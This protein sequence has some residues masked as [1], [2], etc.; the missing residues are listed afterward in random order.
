[1]PVETIPFSQVPTRRAVMALV[2]RD[3]IEVPGISQEEIRAAGEIVASVSAHQ[4]HSARIDA[5]R[6]AAVQWIAAGIETGDLAGRLFDRYSNEQIASML[7]A[8]EAH[9]LYGGGMQSPGC[10]TERHPAF[11]GLGKGR[12]QAS[13]G[14]AWT[15][16]ISSAGNPFTCQRWD[17]HYNREVP[18]CPFHVDA[19]LAI[20]FHSRIFIDGG[21]ED[22]TATPAEAAALYTPEGFETLLRSILLRPECKDEHSRAALLLARIR[23]ERER[24]AHAQQEAEL[25]GVVGVL[26]SFQ[27]VQ[28]AGACED[29]ILQWCRQHGISTDHPQPAEK[30]LALADDDSRGYIRKAIEIARRRG[31]TKIADIVPDCF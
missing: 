24:K 18:V 3:L 16:A 23:L 25:A 21:V 8:G 26:V 12:S 28:D 9:G 6:T 15:A 5:A 14:P 4:R 13:D 11:T 10:G 29:G 2:A 17:S 27:D 20:R 30:L 22:V 19:S 31:R 7:C 1:M